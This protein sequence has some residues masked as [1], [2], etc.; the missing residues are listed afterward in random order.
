MPRTCTAS[1]IIHYHDN[2]GRCGKH[3][4][5]ITLTDGKSLKVWLDKVLGDELHRQ[6]R[7]LA[8][9]PPHEVRYQFRHSDKWGDSLTLI[10]STLA[11][12]ELAD[13]ARAADEARGR[14]HKQGGFVA[15]QISKRVQRTVDDQRKEDERTHE[16]EMGR[17]G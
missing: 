1:A 7:Q 12:Y 6:C 5:T 2:L 9:F 3:L 4:G 11:D 16:R 8:A 15:E 13:L 17:V 14:S 10:Q